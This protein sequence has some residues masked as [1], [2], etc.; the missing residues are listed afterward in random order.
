MLT[1]IHL[2]AGWRTGKHVSNLIY[3]WICYIF[4]SLF[5]FY[6]TQRNQ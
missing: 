4:A 1:K 5:A 6:V 2:E 3:Y